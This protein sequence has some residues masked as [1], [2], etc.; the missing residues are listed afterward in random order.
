MSANRCATLITNN[1]AYYDA[2]FFRISELQLHKY[3]ILN[4]GLSRS[5]QTAQSIQQSVYGR[6]LVCLHRYER[7][8]LFSQCTSKTINAVGFYLLLLSLFLY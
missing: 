6:R 2:N 8:R 5:E 3:W 7:I 4:I 1:D